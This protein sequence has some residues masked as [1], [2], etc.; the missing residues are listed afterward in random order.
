MTA[1]ISTDTKHIVPEIDKGDTDNTLSLREGSSVDVGPNQSDIVTVNRNRKGIARRSLKAARDSDPEVRAKALAP[2]DRLGA[3]LGVDKNEI[4]EVT[5]PT[6]WIHATIFIPCDQIKALEDFFRESNHALPAHKLV[7]LENNNHYRIDALFANRTALDYVASTFG[8]TVC[9][10]KL[11]PERRALFVPH[12]GLINAGTTVSTS[13]GSHLNPDAGSGQ[14]LG[15]NAL[16][17]V[18]S[19]VIAAMQKKKEEVEETPDFASALTGPVAH[20]A[21]NFI[22]S[23]GEEAPKN[24]Q[25]I[26]LLI[27]VTHPNLRTILDDL[28]VRLQSSEN[29]LGEKRRVSRHYFGQLGNY[30][31]AGSCAEQG[32]IPIIARAVGEYN[33]STSNPDA[34]IFINT[35]KIQ[36]GHEGL[37]R[38]VTNLNTID[39][40]RISALRSGGEPKVALG[41]ALNKIVTRRDD[42]A[43]GVEREGGKLGHVTTE[44]DDAIDLAIVTDVALDNTLDVTDIKRVIGEDAAI[45]IR[46]IVT[47][48]QDK[49]TPYL[50]I[51]GDAGLGKSTLLEQAL[52]RAG[53]S[54]VTATALDDSKYI[55]GENLAYIFLAIARRIISDESRDPALVKFAHDI[56]GTKES[57]RPIAELRALLTDSTKQENY[58]R[59]AGLACRGLGVDLIIDDHHFAGADKEP[60]DKFAKLF[61]E[62]NPG[63]KIIFASRNPHCDFA[64]KDTKKVPVTGIDYNE[65]DNARHHLEDCLGETLLMLDGRRASVIDEQAKRIGARS[66]RNPLYFRTIAAALID[67]KAGSIDEHGVYRIDN[68]FLENVERIIT[69]VGDQAQFCTGRLEDL[70]RSK[71]GKDARTVVE[72]IALLTRIPE[73]SAKELIG[74]VCEHIDGHEDELLESLVE[75]LHLVLV[76]D[77]VTGKPF[78]RPAHPGIGAMIREEMTPQHR[79]ERQGMLDSLFG[80]HLDLETRFKLQLSIVGDIGGDQFVAALGSPDTPE[81]QALLDFI[82]SFNNNAFAFSETLRRRN[83]IEPMRRTAEIIGELPMMSLVQKVILKPNSEVEQRRTQ[84]RLQ[85]NNAIRFSADTIVRGLLDIAHAAAVQGRKDDAQKAL[86]ELNR[87]A[88]VFPDLIDRCDLLSVEFNYHYL[89]NTQGD[90]TEFRRIYDALDRASLEKIETL[91]RQ[92]TGEFSTDATACKTLALRIVETIAERAAYAHEFNYRAQSQSDR[93]LPMTDKE[94]IAERTATIDE[95]HIALIVEYNRAHGAHNHGIPSAAVIEGVRAKEVLLPFKLLQK[96]L[97]HPDRD[98]NCIGVRGKATARKYDSFLTE[99]PHFVTAEVS[100]EALKIIAAVK[101]LLAIREDKGTAL[102]P[103]T[104]VRLYNM[105]LRLQR[106]LGEWNEAEKTARQGLDLALGVGDTIEAATYLTMLLST[107]RYVA[108]TQ[109]SSS[110]PAN[111]DGKARLSKSWALEPRKYVQLD[112]LLQALDIAF[113]EAAESIRRQMAQNPDYSF[114][115]TVNTLETC[116]TITPSN[117]EITAQQAAGEGMGGSVS[118]RAAEKA[119]LARIG[120]AL[121]K[122][123]EYFSRAQAHQF[124]SIE[125]LSANPTAGESQSYIIPAFARICAL[126]RTY[127]ATDFVSRRDVAAEDASFRAIDYREIL[128]TSPITRPEHI[129]AA[130]IF[131]NQAVA[132][133]PRFAAESRNES[134]YM[135]ALLLESIDHATDLGPFLEVFEN[136]VLRYDLG[137]SESIGSLS[138]SAEKF[139][140]PDDPEKTTFKQHDL[141]ALHTPFAVDT[142]NHRPILERVLVRI[143]AL[144]TANPDDVSLRLAGIKAHFLLGNYN[145]AAAELAMGYYDLASR[146]SEEYATLTARIQLVIGKTAQKDEGTVICHASEFNYGNLYAAL[147]AGRS[148]DQ[149]R[150]TKMPIDGTA[151]G[152]PRVLKP[153][154]EIEKDIEAMLIQLDATHAIART[155][156]VQA[157]MLRRSQKIGELAT[158]EASSFDI[159]QAANRMARIA[160]PDVKEGA[161]YTPRMFIDS[162]NQGASTGNF[163]AAAVANGI[164]ENVFSF[165]LQNIQIQKDELEALL[166]TYG[167]IVPNEEDL[168]R[169]RNN[170]INT[171]ITN[172]KNPVE[173]LGELYTARLEKEDYERAIHAIGDEVDN[174]S[175]VQDTLSRAVEIVS[176]INNYLASV[177]GNLNEG[178]LAFIQEFVRLTTQNIRGWIHLHNATMMDPALHVNDAV[179]ENLLV[180]SPFLPTTTGATIAKD[181][182]RQSFIKDNNFADDIFAPRGSDT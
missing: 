163:L 21:I 126:I 176:R 92:M 94:A 14:I 172:G 81:N 19:G 15:L 99:G 2:I 82:R 168:Q 78:Y 112:P 111:T 86:S 59:R 23:A 164:P 63:R 95:E 66:F 29:N 143:L 26:F 44:P 155:I 97:Q 102:P 175:I 48:L 117:I 32:A 138:D 124:A 73:A 7:A 148:L 33:G 70:D 166:S 181:R 83:A 119:K 141:L 120:C 45:A 165:A 154:I 77:P 169:L 62:C 43:T 68:E 84:G 153:S 129:L 65:G 49:D 118:K 18:G 128:A 106:Q 121:Q 52:Q 136:T 151:V 91:M 1:T 6:G 35:G 137:S 36:D 24:A 88:E 96:K 178:Q 182:I 139:T 12:N 27:P 38:R 54:T 58:M 93:V 75:G 133:D 40:S 57:P 101:K 5:I 10:S 147:K 140:N 160:N 131:Q 4:T 134:C 157:R 167:I 20:S 107:L 123:L 161:S 180:L 174:P 76:P 61:K 34:K 142:K 135:Q 113:G 158:Q 162:L 146:A 98:K 149:Y 144:L 145:T 46:D 150:S 13:L 171:A 30:I 28:N 72:C 130:L 108:T 114:N 156:L 16:G 8:A 9:V 41:G 11:T 170:L 39:L 55:V 132:V 177:N 87:I 89:L 60:V 51:H 71:F 69:G 105:L 122:S 127:N 47:A 115:L 56:Y 53:H 159:T 37:L 104:V 74:S 85:N 42:R 50:Y 22:D 125:A 3:Y 90:F 100:T 116:A 25:S 152:S 103:N 80:K 173:F 79:R 67:R 110:A 109:S 64:D 31:V 17:Q 179:L